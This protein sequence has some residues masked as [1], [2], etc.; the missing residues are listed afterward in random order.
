MVD[1]VEAF[2]SGLRVGWCHP[3]QECDGV[4]S[5]FPVSCHDEGVEVRVLFV[6][7]SF[8]LFSS[9]GWFLLTVAVGL[10]RRFRW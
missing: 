4:V 5:E 9:E 6:F 10:A 8:V 3:S 2:G 7:P 1:C